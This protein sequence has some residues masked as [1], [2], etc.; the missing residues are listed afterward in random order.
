MSLAGA[1]GGVSMGPRLLHNKQH[2]SSESLQIYKTTCFKLK[3]ERREVMV[4]SNCFEQ[5]DCALSLDPIEPITAAGSAH[6]AKRTI[7]LSARSPD[8]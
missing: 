3:S 4:G 5:L 2:V 1:E 8:R 7:A 6:R